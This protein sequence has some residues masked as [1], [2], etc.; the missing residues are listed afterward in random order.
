[1]PIE[2]LPRKC[3]LSRITYQV[4]HC[5]PLQKK[6]LAKEKKMLL[7]SCRKCPFLIMHQFINPQISE[8]TSQIISGSFSG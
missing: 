2:T 8:S 4:V 3:Y 6:T 5:I 1:M 7:D